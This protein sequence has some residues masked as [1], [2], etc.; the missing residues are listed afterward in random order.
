MA[1]SQWS[2][3]SMG[4]CGLAELGAVARSTGPSLSAG[5]MA[6]MQRQGLNME[7]SYSPRN[8]STDYRLYEIDKHI[9]DCRIRRKAA[10]MMAAC[11]TREGSE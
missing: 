3:D 11:A 6:A 5:G 1:N 9:A 7:S 2:W 10:I 4:R 8:R